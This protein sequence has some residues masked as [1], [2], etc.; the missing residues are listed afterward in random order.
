M[1]IFIDCSVFFTKPKVVFTTIL[2]D[3]V[4]NRAANIILIILENA[5]FYC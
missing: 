2:L 1:L 5:M 4:L 3:Y